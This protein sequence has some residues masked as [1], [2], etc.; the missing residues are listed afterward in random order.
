MVLSINNVVSIGL[1]YEISN[2][3]LEFAASG[4]IKIN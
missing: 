4:G 1:S 2:R 3:D